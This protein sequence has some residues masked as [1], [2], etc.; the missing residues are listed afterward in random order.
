[1]K[2]V[3]TAII[4]AGAWGTALAISAAQNGH[5][6]RLWCHNEDVAKTITKN[7][8]N[9]RHLKGLR[10]P[11]SIEITSLMSFAVKDCEIIIFAV[12]SKFMFGPMKNLCEAAS[13]ESIILLATKGV[14]PDSLLLPVELICRAPNNWPEENVA[15][16]SGPS[17][18]RELA[19]K[20][21]TAVTVAG[22]NKTNVERVISLFGSPS[23]RL[24]AHD[25][26]IGL[27]IG[28]AVKN[29]VAIAA[30]I[31]DGLEF[32]YNTRAALITRGLSEIKRL[33]IAMGARGETFSGLSGLGDLV[34]TCTGDLSRNRQVGLRLGCGETIDEISKS[35]ADV[36]E[37]VSTVSC[38]RKL[39]EKYS[40]S[41]PITQEV[42]NVIY[43]GKN[44]KTAVADL[45]GRAMKSEF[46]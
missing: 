1:M 11:E 16:L 12:P 23:F 39:A 13:R 32:G 43:G 45:M 21:P 17:F 20:M 27:E 36:A 5:A 15:V 14:A 28:G 10:L 44:P 34:L 40:V 33:G 2:N 31:C 30:G 3:K 42:Y 41:M 29:V 7:R 22:K 37:G 4:G 18:A 25:D 38:I 6:V 24:Y 26:T 35:M 9:I 46:D 19:R 8:E